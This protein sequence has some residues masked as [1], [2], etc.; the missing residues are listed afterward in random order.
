ML[1]VSSR[2]C[3]GQREFDAAGWVFERLAWRVFGSELLPIT[4]NWE[5]VRTTT[6]LKYQ[7]LPQ[8]QKLQR[9]GSVFPGLSDEYTSEKTGTLGLDFFGDTWASNAAS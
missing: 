2:A 6:D 9:D 4:G 5:L 8:I 7:N 3:M 1:D